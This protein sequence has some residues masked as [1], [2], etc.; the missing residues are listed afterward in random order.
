[1]G[2]HRNRTRWGGSVA[3][4]CR[5]RSLPRGISCTWCSNR[6]LRCSGRVFPPRISRFAGGG[7]R[8][9][10]AENISIRIPNLV[11]PAM[12]IA[13]IVNG[14]LKRH[15]GTTYT[16]CSS[17]LIL[18]SNKIVPTISLKSTMVWIP[19]DNPTENSVVATM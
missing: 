4:R 19:V 8:R 2:I 18:N 7:C 1:M 11:V 6:M 10:L 5:I 13:L 12:I 16:P 14:Q 9:V 3:R 15:L 17:P